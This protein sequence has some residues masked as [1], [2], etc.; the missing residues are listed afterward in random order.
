MNEG[1]LL[2]PERK[3]AAASARLT[4]AMAHVSAGAPAQETLS[5][6]SDVLAVLNQES[7]LLGAITLA[8]STPGSPDTTSP[9]ASCLAPDI[10]TASSCIEPAPPGPNM[11]ADGPGWRGPPPEVY[12]RALAHYDVRRLLREGS[13]EVRSAPL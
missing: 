12:P 8:T 1:V 10:D 9:V 13:T 6:L 4:Q 3:R 2:I 5:L 7:V 11:P